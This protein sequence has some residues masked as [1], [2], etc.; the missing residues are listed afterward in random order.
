MAA[1][2]L[3]GILTENSFGKPAI[4]WR[5]F[6]AEVTR[7]LELILV[8]TRADLAQAF[9]ARCP[10]VA[11][12]NLFLLQTDDPTLLP[13]LF[14]TEPTFPFIFFADA[15]EKGC[16]LLCLSIGLRNFL[17][18]RSMG[19]RIMARVLPP[20]VARCL[21]GGSRRTVPAC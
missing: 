4:A 17:P 15:A 11:L 6:C 5:S 9:P 19:G 20:T 16:A 3:R 18:E 8:A 2:G 13:V 1:Q 7:A 10:E 21:A 12:V 14:R